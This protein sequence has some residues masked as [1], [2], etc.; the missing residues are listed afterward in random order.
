MTNGRKPAERHPLGL[1]KVRGIFACLSK[2]IHAKTIYASN[3]PNVA[4]FEAA[5][6]RSFESY[7]RDDKELVLSV[8]QYR[9]QWREETVYE[10]CEKAESIA[11]LLYKD[12]VG[13]I[14]FQSS[15]TPAELDRFVDLL[16]TEIFNPSSHLDVVSRLWQA[17]FA[18]ISYRVFDECAEGAPGEG[19]GSGS[20]SRE[21]PLQAGDHSAVA[22]A[23]PSNGAGS[24]SGGP[25]DSLGAYLEGLV[26]RELRRSTPR[27]REKRLQDML[28]YLFS[29]SA[30]EL[31]SWRNSC[32]RLDDGNKL[33]R[34]LNIMLDFAELRSAPPVVRDID[35][36]ISRLV[37]FIVEEAHLPTLVALLD[38]QRTICRNRLFAVD[39]QSLPSRIEHE[40]TNSA[41]LLSLG[42]TK[43]RTP[44]DAHEALN[45]FRL[46]GEKA[47]PGVCELLTALKDPILHKSACD[48]LIDIAAKDLP[49]IVNDL[50]LDNPYEARDALYLLRRAANKEIHPVALKLIVSTDL[51]VREQV[52]EYLAGVANDEA[53][54]LLCRLL[55][56]DD[57]GIRTK[58]FAAI[59]E[60]R[61]PAVIEKVLAACFADDIA[62]KGADELERMFRAAGKLG[63]ERTV[64]S[65]RQMLGKGSWF[66]LGKG[67]GRQN[68]LLAV[69]ALRHI[70]GPE[71]LE[72]LRE[73]AQDGDSLVRT[74][75]VYALKHSGHGAS[76]PASDPVLAAGGD[77]AP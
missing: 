47:V 1:E 38:N 63:R 60:F 71:A 28:T 13:E 53:A 62:S 58:T 46:V 54:I 23:A 5:F 56:D 76:S 29:S 65:V 74:K 15:V 59:E 31:A 11:F 32:A 40:L 72:S 64:A 69:T 57:P 55:D 67:R 21:Q 45:Y 68:K 14:T 66:R 41:F 9:I 51:S 27:E 16:R 77:N 42:K 37:R 44:Q 33:L 4:N 43:G 36:I 52:I 19:R 34:L 61:H 49:R 2:Y 70:P 17:E 26:E 75:A 48:C 3:N 73:L 6:Y 30:D 25:P 39:F 12:G 20:E 7:F 10:N 8:E 50:N 22:L 18:G 35:D 24:A